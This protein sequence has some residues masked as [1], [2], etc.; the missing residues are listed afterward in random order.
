MMTFVVAQNVTRATQPL[1]ARE[2]V[3]FSSNEDGRQHKSKKGNGKK[4]VT[5]SD[6]IPS[7]QP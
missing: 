6:A 4:A 1:M 2:S 3:N 7:A 5:A